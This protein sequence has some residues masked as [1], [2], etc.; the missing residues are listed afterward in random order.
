MPV[1]LWSQCQVPWSGLKRHQVSTHSFHT[2]FKH[3]PGA[4]LCA[5]C[6]D[7]AV[8]GL[9]WPQL[10]ETGGGDIHQFVAIVTVIREITPFPIS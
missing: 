9:V 1:M 4:D 5:G 10:L 3:P 8:N 6:W 2:R 7:G